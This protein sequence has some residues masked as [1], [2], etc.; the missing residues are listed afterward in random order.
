VILPRR[1]EKDLEDVPPAIRASM[2]FVFVDTIE[3][4]LET[5]LE[6]NAEPLRAAA[7]QD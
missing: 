1:N 3:Q 5:A 2:R 7:G 6:P 4:V